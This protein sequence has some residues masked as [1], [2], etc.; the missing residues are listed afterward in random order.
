MVLIRG[1]GFCV[2]M[3]LASGLSV[4]CGNTGGGGTSS[5]RTAYD[6]ELAKIEVPVGLAL[7]ADGSVLGKLSAGSANTQVAN[8]DAEV[9]FKGMTLR[10]PP[11]A[12][13][14]DQELTLE[15][16]GS[17]VHKANVTALFGPEAKIVGVGLPVEIHWTY[18][19]NARLPYEVSLPL[20]ALAAKNE[21]AEVVVVFLQNDPELGSFRLTGLNKEQLSYADGKVKFNAS[22]YGVVQ[23]AWVESAASTVN[24]VSGPADLDKVVSK[25]V[26][27]PFATKSLT[28]KIHA[29]KV[30]LSW[31]LSE[32]A[33]SY[34]IRL[35]EGAADCAQAPVVKPNISGSSAV[36]TFDKSGEFAAC[37]FAVNKNGRTAASDGPVKLVID[38]EAP[39]T[40]KTAPRSRGGPNLNT[41][42]IVLDWDAV[43][44]SGPAGLKYYLLRVGT[45]PGSQD[46]FNDAVTGT[47]KT[48]V[49][50][51]GQSYYAQ[52]KAVDYA[53]NESE[54]SPVSEKITVQAE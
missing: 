46:L 28:Q 34:E 14:A 39:A 54:W 41:I 15:L 33:N 20:A 45:T 4:S 6:P 31:G 53:G 10:F 12:F 29:K 49:A 16:F 47:A 21:S 48:V 23:A 3:F 38:A 40:P 5:S 44:D 17:I 24:E 7:Q 25:D 36:L 52:V 51:D 32:F 11:T 19:E 18:D 35:A 2:L 37:V 26:P 13:D 43:T 9:P 27:G 42:Q 50:F 22:A 8:V 1:V 30:G